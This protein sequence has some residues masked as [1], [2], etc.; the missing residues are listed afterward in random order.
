MLLRCGV[1][2]ENTAE[3]VLDSV[4]KI[5]VLGAGGWGT[6]L[7]VMAN[8]YGNVVTLWTKFEDEAALI[9]Q[10][11]EHKKLLPGIPVPPSLALTTDL[12]CVKEAELVL[13]A[14]PSFAIAETAASMRDF[15][16]S[17]TPVAICGKGLEDGT[18]RR[19]SQVVRELLPA[20]RVVALSGPS[21]AE[22]VGRGVPTSVVSASEDIQAAELVQEL[23]MN[24]A[25]RI[26][27][28]A[29]VIGVE[30]G[31]ALKNIIALAA[32]ICDGLDMGDNTKAALMTRGLA[33]MARLG[34][35]MGASSETFAGLSGMGDL[36]VTCGSMHS[37]N[38]RAGILIG[39]GR[40]P[41]EAVKLVGTV[42]GYLAARAAWHLAQREGVEMPITEQC[43]RVCYQGQNPQDAI[44]AL[45][46]RPKK[47]ES[48]IPWLYSGK[49]S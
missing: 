6:A 12:S 43:Y 34:T 23:L 48:E 21:H 41:E 5:A 27:V 42:E 10:H 9:R 32:G 26:Y 31:G 44:H 3:R 1:S 11:G 13:L 14:V 47:H 22:E 4:A 7:A 16:P 36:I 8:R 2:D 33:E 24:P 39:Q 25:F 28:N 46:G 15:L 40:T 38:R 35:A 17:G 20:A 37:R 29:D 18:H 19:F 45:M 30:L 49:Q